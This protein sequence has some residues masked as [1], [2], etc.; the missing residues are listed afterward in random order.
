MNDL[1]QDFFLSEYNNFLLVQQD[2]SIIILIFLGLVGGLISSISPCVLTLLPMNLAYIGTLEISDRKSAFIKALQFITGVALV[3]SLLGLFSSLAFVVFT[4][5]KSFLFTSIGIFIFLMGLVV[6]DLIRLPLPQFIK[7]MPETNPFIIG[8]LFALVSSPCSSP[9]LF[10][11]LSLA[12]STGSQ[13]Y[14]MLIMFA[15]SLGY[16]A[17]IFL[18]SLFAGILKQINLLKKHSSL[19]NK[20]SAAF[21]IIIGIVYIYLGFI[22][23]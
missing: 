23:L 11:V 17:L 16:T 2:S 19:I 12:S 22:S 18:A 1:S 6:L 15:Y 7:K 4:E 14:S 20:I 5:K 10:G 9:V 8:L 13:I 21:L 3:L